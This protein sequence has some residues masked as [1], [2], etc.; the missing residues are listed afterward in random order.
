MASG[1]MRDSAKKQSQP[2]LWKRLLL[3]VQED[4]ERWLRF[5]R[6]FI[7][8]ILLTG[9]YAFITCLLYTSPSPRDS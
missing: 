4:E 6:I 7:G 8:N 3:P 1:L 5:L 2:A 9:A